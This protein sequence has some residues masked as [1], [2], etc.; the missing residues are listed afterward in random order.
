MDRIPITCSNN[1]G[2]KC[3]IEYGMVHR[4]RTKQKRKRTVLIG[5]E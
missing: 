5:K 1:F 4:F 3:N 2:V